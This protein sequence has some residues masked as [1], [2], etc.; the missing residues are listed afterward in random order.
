M[1]WS[2]ARR[3]LAVGG[4]L[5]VVVL[6]LLLVV[7]VQLGG[8]KAGEGPSAAP[9]S[10]VPTSGASSAG[11]S[12]ATGAGRQLPPPAGV[13]E[14]S[15]WGSAVRLE[16][17]PLVRAGSTTVLTGVLSV[18]TAS[19]RGFVSGDSFKARGQGH[20]SQYSFSDVRL[21]AP[22]PGLLASPATWSD[23]R[24]ATTSLGNEVG[25][26]SG[27][28]AGLR[29]VFGALPGEVRR[30]DVLWPHLGV[31]PDL[32]VVDG[33]V[34]ALPGFGRE[35]PRDVQLAGAVG[36]VN[37]VT[38]RLSQ[39]KGAVKTE[40]A[41]AQ[42]KV[43]L[44]ADV[45]F[46]LDRADLSPQANAALDAAAAAVEAAGPGPVKVTGH[47]DD[48]GAEQYNLDLSNRRAQSV[49]G[50]LTPRLAPERYP[51]QVSGRGEAEPAVQGTT[52]EA[53]A[54]NRRVEL[55]VERRQQAAPALP[56]AALAPG[57]GL[58]AKGSDG[59]AFDQYD[60][61][62]VR[63]RADRAVRQGNWLRVDLTI[64]VER[65]DPDDPTTEFFP[66][67]RDVTGRSVPGRP[68]AA[69]VGVLDGA[70]LHLPAVVDRNG[71]CACPNTL[72]GLSMEGKEQRRFS[73]WVGAPPNLGATVVVQLPQAQGRL[74]DVPVTPK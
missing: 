21:F 27:E 63:L 2:P 33:A 5:V 56:P 73:I 51:L 6:L 23:G 1:T 34:P 71:V 7:A 57:G 39:L 59:L 41:P 64:D 35:P 70:V 17:Q 3:R 13:V 32:P 60:R 22:E 45:L 53:R 38:G 40:Q 74:V 31:V 46:A 20:V 37:R 66:D 43:V 44:A 19:Q 15:L 69:G 72:A 50:A 8:D 58:S 10:G 52:A 18:V 54:A 16:V 61:S 36:Q 26:K 14:G 24:A 25:L 11:G 68:D 42:T 12:P 49:A 62:R 28:S 48:Q 4:A 9:T 29:V 47:T 65:P 55:V 67:L 30:A